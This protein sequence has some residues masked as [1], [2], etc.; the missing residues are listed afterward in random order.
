MAAIDLNVVLGSVAFA[1]FWVLAV[2]RTVPF[3][4]IGRTA[5][6]P[7]G[8]LLM[9]VFRVIKPKDAYEA[10]DLPILGLLFGSMVVGVYLE[11]AHMFK[12]LGKLLSW[13]S[14]GAKDLL[15][16]IC[17]VSAISS[18]LFTNDTTCVVLT[19]FVLKIATQKNLPPHPFLFALVSSANIG[20]S[21]SP[22]GNPQNLIIAVQSEIPFGNFLHGILP[23]MVV[24]VF[25]NALILLCMYWK[26]L[27]IPKDEENQNKEIEDRRID[28][29]DMNSH[30]FSPW[31]QLRRILL[32]EIASQVI[33]Q[34]LGN[35]ENEIIIQEGISW[36]SFDYLVII[37]M[38]IS[39]FKG[40]DMTWTVVTTAFT[41]AVLDFKDAQPCLEKVSYSLLTFFCG[42]FV[43]VKGFNETGIPN[44]IWEFI[45][46]Y[47]RIDHFRGIV[48]LAAV[49]VVLS[50][51]FSNV[52]T[53]LLVGKLVAK[54]AASISADTNR[55]W[56]ILAWV[57]TVAGNFSLV[58]SAANLIVWEQA[59]QAW[60]DGYTLSFWRHLKFGV[61]S[62]LIITAIGL[63]L[64]QG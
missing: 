22:I 37:G 18:A 49:I 5:G 63:T 31:R 4:P 10:I 17:L 57:S 8:A 25:V 48:V 7:L 6:S 24:G 47:A 42:M 11:K 35:Q 9:V 52:P 32:T 12:Y 2:F 45:E 3:L 51:L 58:G 62:T 14:Y 64:I 39:L 33:D 61:P 16:R 29:N 19:E 46:P 59:R 44:M 15:C 30:R 60:D 20:S 26:L 28:S 27:S 54:S 1:I 41:L 36:K 13:K 56:L 40:F 55:A 23:A 50:N 34:T 53:V 43:T 21:A 38:L